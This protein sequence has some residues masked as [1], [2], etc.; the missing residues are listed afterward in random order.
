MPIAVGVAGDWTPWLNPFAVLARAADSERLRRVLTGGPVV[1]M[2][3]YTMTSL[4]LLAQPIVREPAKAATGQP[5]SAMSTAAPP[6][7]SRTWRVGD[8][9][10][11]GKVAVASTAPLAAISRAPLTWSPPDPVGAP[12]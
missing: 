5:L 2:V 3:A 7:R 11:R 9:A 6:P 8:Q 10:E 4:W 12:Q 1:A